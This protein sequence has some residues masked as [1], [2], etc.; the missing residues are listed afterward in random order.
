M[1]CQVCRYYLGISSGENQNMWPQNLSLQYAGDFD[2]T[3]SHKQGESHSKLSIS[4]KQ[5]LQMESAVINPLPRVPASKEQ[6]L[7]LQKR[8][9]QHCILKYTVITC[10]GSHLFFEGSFILLKNNLLRSNNLLLS[11]YILLMCNI[12]SQI[13]T[14]FGIPFL[15]W[16][17]MYTII[18]NT[19][20]YRFCCCIFVCFALFHRHSYLAFIFLLWYREKQITISYE[21][22]EHSQYFLLTLKAYL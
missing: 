12:G 16:C 11:S 14:V 22:Q 17:P 13:L 10:Y 4:L 21:M 9:K 1:H 15:F 5:I 8:W 7:L 6:W 2:L 18:I 20:V 3:E 19:F